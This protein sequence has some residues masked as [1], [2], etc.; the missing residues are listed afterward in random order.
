MK[1][2]THK[3]GLDCG[4]PLKWNQNK[5][6]KTTENNKEVTCKKCLRLINDEK[7]EKLYEV[8]FTNF[9]GSD[10]CKTIKAP[11][12]SK[13]IY[14]CF[15][16]FMYDDECCGA[17]IGEQF[18][19]FRNDKPKAKL[20]KDKN[21]KQSL[22]YEEEDQLK[23]DEAQKRADEFNSKYPIGTKVLFQGDGKYYPIITTTR[24]EAIVY[25]DYLTIFLDGV[26]GSYLLDD[27]FVRVL[28]D[29]NK[30]LE[31]LR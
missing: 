29:E 10:S 8:T 26:S 18:R 4:T 17:N 27:R 3:K 6:E 5:H 21:V 30:N 23:K 16:L 28:T 14:K 31:R 22:T 13:A 9:D 2:K 7:T 1:F 15:K 20:I 11:T 19:W 25:A 24:S 12:S